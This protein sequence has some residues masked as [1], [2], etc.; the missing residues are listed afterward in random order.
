MHLA[1]GTLGQLQNIIAQANYLR[2]GDYAMAGVFLSACLSV[3]NYTKKTTNRIFVKILSQM[4][5][6][7]RKISLNFGRHT[8]LNHEDT[9]SEILATFHCRDVTV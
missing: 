2:Y 8:P 4:F 9:K 6:W 5:L 7:T 1:S 3:S